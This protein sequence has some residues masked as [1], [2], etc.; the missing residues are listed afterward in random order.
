[1]KRTVLTALLLA[2]CVGID[3]HK[4]PPADWPRVMVVEH[5]VSTLEM[6]GRCYQYVPLA[7]KLLGGVP[8]ACMEINLNKLTCDIWLTSWSSQDTV[9]HE[10]L[11]CAGHDHYEDDT[12]EQIY[13]AWKGT[14]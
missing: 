3:T 2:G 10:R 8:L 7:L 5:R 4:A 14:L 1:M 13:R 11:H 12:L 9:E 6:L